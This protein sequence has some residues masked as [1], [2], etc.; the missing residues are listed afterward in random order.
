M[1]KLEKHNERYSSFLENK[2]VAIVGPSQ[3]AFFNE[4][5][6][7]ID[8]FD[9]IVRI[10]RGMELLPGR[11]SFIGSRT[12]ILYNSLDFDIISGGTLRGV[13]DQVKFICCPYSVE[14]HTYR[15][16]F[17]A[18]IFD[19][20]NIRFINTDVYNKVK[21]DTN[22]RINSGFGAIVDL[23]QHDIQQLFITGIDFYR[24]FYHKSYCGER[25]R[26]ATVRAIEEELEFK[27]YND[28]NHH[29]PDRQY[30][31]FKEVIGKDTR[32]VMDSFLTKIIK[33]SKYD[34][35]DTIPR[36]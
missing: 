3:S 29:N 2:R 18:P 7:Y 12:D 19:K 30:A 33:D 20:F 34:N 32:V 21:S 23:L 16:A 15:D 22:S 17:V 25:N 36:D 13:N 28:A 11:E 1:K 31:Y 8:S 9:V 14:E 5:G 24:S 6:S 35:W 27:Q 26:S 4:N 10:N